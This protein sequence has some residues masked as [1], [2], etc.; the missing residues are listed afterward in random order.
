MIDDDVKEQLD[1]IE[2]KLDALIAALAE[3]ESPAFD[4]DGNPVPRER[5]ER[6]TL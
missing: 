5:N 1:R 4:L 2:S 6:E 3:E